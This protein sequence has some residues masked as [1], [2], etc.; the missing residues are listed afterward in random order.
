[1]ALR[2]WILFIIFSISFFSAF[3]GGIKGKVLDSDQ[4]PVA[5]ATLRIEGTVWGAV[6]GENGAYL[7][8]DVPSGTYQLGVTHLGFK[9][10]LQ[11]IKVP[12]SGM[13]EVNFSLEEI[14]TELGQVTI[15]EKSVSQEL[16]ESPIQITSIDV[17]KLQNEAADVV[18]VLD[19]TAGVRVRQ[20]GGMGSRT[21]IQLNGLSGRAVRT[22]YDGIP[23][24]LLGGGIQLNNIPVNTVE[25]VDIYKGVMPIDVG[26]DALAG[27]INVISRKVAFDYLDAAYQFG[28]FNSH[29]GSLNAAKKI[30]DHL[31]LSFSSF[32]NHSDNNYKIR[33]RQ[34][35]ANFQEIEV[36]V[37]RFHSGH[38]SS[39][40][41]GSL[42]VIDT[43]WADNFT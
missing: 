24:E 35:T 18:S 14:E 3:A 17:V 32:Y 38:Q 9:K 31:L 42:G 43:K 10:S 13:L 15:T 29:V 37:E 11:E 40:V 21:S 33:A 36:E 28:S 27:G 16:S 34:R 7:I 26:T 41:M 5:G 22:Y 4:K 1:M 39:M 20:S 8:P 6:S 30:G 23:L 25:R 2:P 12:A 19:R